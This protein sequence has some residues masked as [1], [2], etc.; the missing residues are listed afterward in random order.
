MIVMLV[1]FCVN[2]AFLQAL[3][4]VIAHQ[5][6]HRPEPSE[7]FG[8]GVGGELSDFSFMRLELFGPRHQVWLRVVDVAA[9]LQ[10]IENL[11]AQVAGLRV[12]EHLEVQ[13]V[14]FLL[15][16]RLS[17]LANNLPLLDE[18]S[19]RQ[20][21]GRIDFGVAGDEL[22]VSNS[23]RT[24]AGVEAGAGE[25]ND[26]SPVDREDRCADRRQ[27]I[28]RRVRGISPATILSPTGSGRQ[29][30]AGSA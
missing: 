2:P 25:F 7:F 28:G 5:V 20:S 29:M 30:S 12:G 13:H 15:V 17:D 10:G 19:F 23:D 22:G 16:V 26:R 8:C 11:V 18:G 1:P 4:I 24:G 3:R 14:R 6:R 9:A 21:F 27:D